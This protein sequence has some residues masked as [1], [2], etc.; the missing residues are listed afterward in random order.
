MC[1]GSGVEFSPLC[2]WDIVSLGEAQLQGSNSGATQSFFTKLVH[3]LQK[4]VWVLGE[5]E[6]MV[7]GDGEARVTLDKV[8]CPGETGPSSLLP[9]LCYSSSSSY[10][11]GQS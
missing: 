5:T 11:Q 8:R 4:L 9:S 6:G 7:S 3:Q 10:G 1:V 2:L